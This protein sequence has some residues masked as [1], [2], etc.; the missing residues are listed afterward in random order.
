MEFAKLIRNKREEKGLTVRA[1][2]R[3]LH[4]RSAGPAISRTLISYLETGDRVP[5]YDVAYAIAD[6]LEIDM[7]NT[8]RAAYLAR[9]KHGQDRESRYV[10]EFLDRAGLELNPDI[11][12]RAKRSRSAQ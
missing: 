11:I 2:E 4:E 9:L 10:R 1:L 3:M 8:I 12:T 7:I 6:V 5:T